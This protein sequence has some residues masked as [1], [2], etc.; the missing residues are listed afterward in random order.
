MYK[1]AQADNLGDGVSG[2]DMSPGIN[3]EE[4]S[5]ENSDNVVDADFEEVDPDAD[6]KDKKDD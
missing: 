6:A 4:G 2:A 5:S 1:A 3:P